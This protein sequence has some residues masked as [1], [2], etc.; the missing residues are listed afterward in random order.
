MVNGTP[1]FDRMARERAEATRTI[2]TSASR[3]KLIV[4][5]PGTGK[6]FTFKEAL[7]AAGAGE[8]GQ[9]GLGL[10]I[11]FIRNLVAD[12]KK[13]LEGLATVFTFH[14]FC[15]HLLH[16]LELS[17]S[18]FDFY[19]ELLTLVA[20][21]IQLL[22][23]PNV[24]K[25]DL[26]KALHDLD[27][28]ALL[29]QTV[30]CGTYYDAASF[31]DVVYRVLRHLQAHPGDIPGYPLVVVDEYQDFSRLETEFIAELSKASP[32]LVAGDDDQ[33][34]YSFKHASASYIRNLATK[35]SG[36][37]LF[38]LPFC[39]RCTEV[40]VE[41]VKHIIERAAQNGNLDGRVPREYICFLPDKA[42]DSAAHPRII[43]ARCSVEMKKAPYLSRYVAGQIALI[44]PEDVA[45]SH[46]KGYP[47]ALVI[48]PP[49]FVEA[50][51]Q[52]LS[53]NGF[54]QAVL[55]RSAQSTIDILD[56]YRR[57]ARKK[58][59]RL[60]WRIIAWCA[61]PAHYESIIPQAIVEGRDPSTLL[62][63]DYCRRHLDTAEL[64]RRLLSDEPLSPDQRK[65]LER[66]LGRPLSEILAALKTDVDGDTGNDPPQST[67]H[68]GE[69][70]EKPSIICT[71]LVGAKGLSAGYVFVVGFNNQDFPR[72]PSGITDT[73]ISC[74]IV[75]LSRGR[76]E[77]HLV[78]CG[79]YAGQ[80]RRVS[81][82]SDWVA[83]YT[84]RR[85]V[86]K[87]YWEAMGQ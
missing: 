82:F 25:G 1:D 32:V 24:S 56:G 48:G 2:V 80:L 49:Y 15:T 22:G 46:E 86:N 31:I 29:R 47:T 28:G 36:Y 16:R 69:H 50:V 34:L 72:D 26:E 18:D 45:E 84:D 19:P 77:C 54:P 60:A 63:A 20:E 70:S 85:T 27:D 23:T 53:N 62:P 43:D 73:E 75:A 66:T 74:F 12:L 13:D 38:G 52:Y 42:A 58:D 30:D 5:G 3:K 7:K 44:P 71:T 64:I 55:R 6:S 65:A 76:K 40:L 67:P 11:T 87:S 8:G 79:R 83:P 78:S 81:A 14:G 39:S 51:H 61:R 37:E 41:A 59:S 57:L 17:D 9:T 68:A 4:A 10:A 33:A 21:D 35:G